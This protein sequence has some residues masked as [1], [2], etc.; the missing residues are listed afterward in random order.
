MLQHLQNHL[1]KK[2]KK[3]DERFAEKLQNKFTSLKG[4]DAVFYN[5]KQETF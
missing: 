5:A 4:T 1:E 3:Q 2:G